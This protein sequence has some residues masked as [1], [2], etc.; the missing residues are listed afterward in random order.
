MSPAP[1]SEGKSCCVRGRCVGRYC[2]A[3]ES[4]IFHCVVCGVKRTVCFEALLIL[5]VSASELQNSRGH[6]PRTP[7]PPR[8]P[9][10]PK[11]PPPPRTPP[12]EHLSLVQNGH[13]E[14]PAEVPVHDGAEDP[15]QGGVVEF[16]YREDLHVPREP[17]VHAWWCMRGGACVVVH[18]WWCMRG[19]ACVVVHTW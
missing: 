2:L 10:P 14:L 6:P 11:S 15:H 3:S 1:H 16:V 8:T 4:F 12:T 18:A 19:G 13:V 5:L 17:V 9:P 7:L